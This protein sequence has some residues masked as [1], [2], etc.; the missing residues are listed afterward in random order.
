MGI[1]NF[2]KDKGIFYVKKN[3]A[4]TGTWSLYYQYYQEGAKLQECVAKLAY[5]ELGL[6]TEM[7]LE[8]ARKRTKQLNSERRLDKDKI[9]NAAERVVE[10]KLID[11]TL[12]P[13][14][15]VNAFF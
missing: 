1:A 14:E 13:P 2:R 9:R 7:T 15:Q 5:E 4:S 6:R 12:F 10:L 8:Q 3:S 11:K